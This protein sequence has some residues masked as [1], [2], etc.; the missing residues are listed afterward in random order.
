MCLRGVLTPVNRNGL[1]QIKNV[2]ALTKAS[3]QKA[4]DVLFKAAVYSSK[5]NLKDTSQRIIFGQTT[6]CGTSQ[7]QIMIDPQKCVNYVSKLP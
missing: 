4:S 1:N 3:F 2:S 5:D 7:C 6:D